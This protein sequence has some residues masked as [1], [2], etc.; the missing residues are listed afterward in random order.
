[1]RIILERKYAQERFS[2][3][4]HLGIVKS[5]LEAKRDS[6]GGEMPLRAREFSELLY[7]RTAFYLLL[8]SGVFGA[9]LVFKLRHLKKCYSDI[10][11]MVRY[12]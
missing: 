8:R 11:R 6:G 12:N 10:M 7:A 3:S 9:A 5:S 1:M 2:S 4:T